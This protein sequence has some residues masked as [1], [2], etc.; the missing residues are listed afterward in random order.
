LLTAL[1]GVFGA[2]NHWLFQVMAVYSLIFI[3]IVA[4]A[5]VVLLIRIIESLRANYREFKLTYEKPKRKR[6][7]E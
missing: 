2:S 7:Q 3:C 6:K 1:A 4:L 5:V